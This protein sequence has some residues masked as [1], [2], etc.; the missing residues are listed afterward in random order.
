MGGGVVVTSAGRRKGGA[1]S[2][3]QPVGRSTGPILMA[4]IL[5]MHQ[6]R[7][8]QATG[9]SIP[10]LFLYSPREVE[11]FVTKDSCKVYLTRLLLLNW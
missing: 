8:S 3:I 1:R 5:G 7:L 11:F 10:R 2:S 6:V 9:V 4:A